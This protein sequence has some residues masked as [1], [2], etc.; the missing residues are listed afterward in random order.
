MPGSG[1][2]LTGPLDSALQALAA[3]QSAGRPLVLLWEA[4]H[5]F[6]GAAMR[7]ARAPGGSER[8]GLQDLSRY[9]ELMELDGVS[10]TNLARYER[11]EIHTLPDQTLILAYFLV[12]N[13]IDSDECRLVERLLGYRFFHEDAE[14]K[15]CGTAAARVLGGRSHPA[16][17][18]VQL[19]TLMIQVL[20]DRLAK[21]QRNGPS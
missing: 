4:T 7:E 11:G 1:A 9:L 20:R 14:R 21:A 8:I 6:V 5:L 12:C 17:R 10:A 3:D 16:V 19:Q 18:A 13:A 15:Q 2:D